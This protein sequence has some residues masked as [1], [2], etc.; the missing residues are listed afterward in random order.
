MLSEWTCSSSDKFINQ[1][2]AIHVVVRNAA[3]RRI[4]II[5]SSIFPSPHCQSLPSHLH[6][7]LPLNNSSASLSFTPTCL[8]S[9][10]G[11]V[12]A[13]PLMLLRA[14]SFKR[15]VSSLRASSVFSFSSSSSPTENGSLSSSGCGVTLV[16]GCHFLFLSASP[17]SLPASLRSAASTS[18]TGPLCGG[19]GGWDLKRFGLAPFRLLVLGGCGGAARTSVMQ[20]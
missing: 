5:S 6:V 20:N 14:A 4:L 1:D 19:N 13:G 16:S 7:F 10:K 8:L 15:S 11:F 2:T 12:P 3:R 18:S 17:A 9:S